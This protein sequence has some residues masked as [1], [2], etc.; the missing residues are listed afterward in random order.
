MY[1][2]LEN[3]STAEDSSAMI[4]V[5][6]TPVTVAI[7]YS[8]NFL[9]REASLEVLLETVPA[10]GETPA[11]Y[12]SVG[13]LSWKSPALLLVAPG[14]YIVRREDL[15]AREITVQLGAVTSDPAE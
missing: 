9:P 8:P 1:P 6:G 12:V 14:S 11:K 2:L 4:V 15:V 7:T 5:A 13:R 3:G 10:A